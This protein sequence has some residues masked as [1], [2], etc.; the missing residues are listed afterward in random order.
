MDE[1]M[2]QYKEFT[3][4]VHSTVTRYTKHNNHIMIRKSVFITHYKNLYGVKW[5][6][7]EKERYVLWEV[8]LPLWILSSR[9]WTFTELI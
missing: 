3:L 4:N 8:V 2:R 7:I 1:E 6:C 9:K 5:K